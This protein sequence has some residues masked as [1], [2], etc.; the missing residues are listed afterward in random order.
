ML[1]KHD[2]P[3]TRNTQ[4][5]VLCLSAS[6]SPTAEIDRELQTAS[7]AGFACVEL[8]APALETYLARH[9]LLWLDMQMREHGIHSLVLNGIELVTTTLG[10]DGEAAPISQARFLELCAHLDTL[11]GGLIVVHPAIGR[12]D[13]K[14]GLGET[15]HA[16]RAYADLAA[17]FEVLLALECRADSTVPDLNAAQDL[18]ERAARSNLRLALSTREW[19]ASEA[20][21]RTLDALGSGLLAL[22][23][24]DHLPGRPPQ[25]S[26]D[27][28]GLPT[29]VAPDLILNLCAHLAAAGFRGP[30]C[31][32]LTSGPGT[33][34]ERAR[35]ARE[36]ACLQL[37]ASP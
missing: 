5:A 34:L 18:V 31:I 32:P 25:G 8:W 7:E 24:L 4:Y 12:E 19:C 9:P 22:V 11:G 10:A 28:Q 1:A 37:Q 13:Q 36:M 30:Y 35:A 26:A 27:R 15:V 21:P 6:R 3:E 20:D 29:R 16:L 23:H 33:P 17:P 2:A 14:A